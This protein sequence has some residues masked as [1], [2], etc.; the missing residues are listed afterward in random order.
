MPLYDVKLETDDDTP[1]RK[2]TSAPILQ[3][4]VTL[5]VSAATAH[6]AGSLAA[7][8]VGGVVGWT[9]LK[10]ISVRQTTREIDRD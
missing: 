9:V 4:V 3:F 6:L 2:N 10:I 5:T 8:L 1:R 7:G